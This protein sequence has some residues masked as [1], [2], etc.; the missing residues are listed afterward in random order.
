MG[1]ISKTLAIV[2]AAYAGSILAVILLVA[3]LQARLLP[4]GYN[5]A[6]ALFL[7][8][9]VRVLCFFFLGASA[10]LYLLP[11]KVIMWWVSVR[12]IHWAPLDVWGS[13][14]SLASCLIAYEAVRR[15]L[16]RATSGGGQFSWQRI[17]LVGGLASVLNSLG[18]TA[19]Q[20][21]VIDPGLIALYFAGDMAGL[22]AVLVG[23]MFVFRL[24][25]ARH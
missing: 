19:L 18:L 7:P 5:L 16:P 8:H 17:A 11:V 15:S 2:T 22:A 23:L 20:S 21:S 6:S 24:H 9:G 25:R 13:A 10:V 3:P 14:V 12:L 4:E 1:D